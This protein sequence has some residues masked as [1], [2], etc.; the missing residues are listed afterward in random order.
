M[1]KDVGM[2]IRIDR[3]LRDEFVVACRVEDESA[4]AVLRQFMR[5]YVAHHM[6]PQQDDP[7]CGHIADSNSWWTQ[8]QVQHAKDVALDGVKDQ[9]NRAMGRDARKF[10]RRQP[11]GGLVNMKMDVRNRSRPPIRKP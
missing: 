10:N 2:R 6:S 1:K 11:R 5:E 4:S 3:Q 9:I 7:F 8:E